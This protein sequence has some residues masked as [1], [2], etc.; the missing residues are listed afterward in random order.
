MTTLPPSPP[1][2]ETGLIPTATVSPVSPV[3]ESVRGATQI[4]VTAPPPV[5]V[6]GGGLTFSRA[7]LAALSL[8]PAAV[9]AD[10]A[11][12]ARRLAPLLGQPDIVRTLRALALAWGAKPGQV[13]KRYYLFRREG[14]RGLVDRRKAGRHWWLSQAPTLPPEFLADWR[15]RVMAHQRCDKR[16]WQALVADW[17]AGKPVPGYSASPPA[18]EITGL[19]AGWS[20]E[21]LRRYRPSKFAKALSR[22]GRFAASH[23]RPTVPL[24]RA[25]L[26]PG[27]MV[28]FDDHHFNVHVTFPGNAACRKALRPSGFFGRDVLSAKWVAWCF[29]ATTWSETT[30]AK[31]TLTERDFFWLLVTYLRDV[32]WRLDTGTTFVVESGTAAVSNDFAERL[33]LASKGKTSFLRSYP[34]DTPPL[35]GLF[36]AQSR[37]NYRLKAGLESQ[38]GDVDDHLAH[39]PGQSGIDRWDCPEELYG[40]LRW[41]EKLILAMTALPPNLARLVQLPFVAFPDFVTAALAAFDLLDNRA[42]HTLEGWTRC[43]HVVNEWR[44]SATHDQWLSEDSLLAL[45]PVQRAAVN[46]HLRATPSLWRTRLLSP[47]EVWSRRDAQNF[48]RLTD[49][50][51]PLVL[52]PDCATPRRVSDDFYLT[53]QDQQ[54]DPEPL[55]YVARARTRTGPV[56]LEPGAEYLVFACPFRPDKVWVCDRAGR[57]LGTCDREIRAPKADQ[58]AVRAKDREIRA[59]TAELMAPI[60]RDARATARRAADEAASNLSVFARARAAR[61]GRAPDDA[62]L[63]ALAEQA[64]DDSA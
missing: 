23:L 8:L 22:T 25:G 21:N 47:A 43:G 56:W 44:V 45:D 51:V 63:A 9:Q 19:P 53:L 60:L 37:G 39:L 61:D 12:W 52:G 1:T 11:L 27:Q 33:Q 40:R 31:K 16:A 13:L 7:D 48:A 58:P 42:D 18:D 34:T 46:A 2:G 32:G 14:L 49:D 10:V 24:T 29:R 59:L 36:A 62:A 57:Y 3:P 5:A 35:P 54:S 55:H 26:R 38:F 6:S 17:R 4:S 64:V 41:S 15:G 20:Y 28:E 30:D 50:L